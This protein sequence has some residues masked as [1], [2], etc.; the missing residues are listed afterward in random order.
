M[1]LPFFFQA[2]FCPPAHPPIGVTELPGL[3]CFSLSVS[4]LFL[5]QVVVGGRANMSN[6]M[7]ACGW[8]SR[9]HEHARVGWVPGVLEIVSPVES[10]PCS[11]LTCL[12]FCGPPTHPHWV[13]LLYVRMVRWP[14]PPTHPR[15]DVSPL[16]LSP[17]G[18][19]EC[20]S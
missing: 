16:V 13:W 6:A 1:Y 2:F 17:A 19:G 14:R 10:P 20:A 8:L 4:P 9:S 3:L 7:G 15:R 11:G 12:L 18:S 5:L